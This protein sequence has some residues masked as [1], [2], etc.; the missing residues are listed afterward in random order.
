MKQTSQAPPIPD[1]FP[2][3]GL[4]PR[5][6]NVAEWITFGI[7][8]CV[9]AAL[10]ALIIYDWALV[11][12]RPPILQV[13]PVGAA[14]EIEEQFYQPFAI[15]NRGGSIAHSVQVIASLSLPGGEVEE[16]QQEINFLAGG[17]RKQGCF[18]FRHHPRQGELL[19][20]VASYKLP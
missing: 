9:L 11:Q 17:E 15:A 3:P 4:P 12:N 5:K 8:C 6:R 7:A 13:A 10:V 2:E 16:G 19:M 1:T 18:I 20:R 14:V